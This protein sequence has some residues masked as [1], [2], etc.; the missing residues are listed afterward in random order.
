[1]YPHARLQSA[2]LARLRASGAYAVNIQVAG[3]AG[4]P[5]ILACIA[6]RFVAIEIKV[7]ER[8]L[9]PLQVERARRIEAAGG[10]RWSCGT[11]TI[12]QRSM[13]E[14]IYVSSH[15]LYSCSVDIAVGFPANSRASCLAIA[16]EAYPNNKP[17]MQ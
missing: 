3:D 1:M 16:S 8:R 5:D 11:S 13:L 10:E 12:L 6:G 17:I 14:I 9:R 4:T 7:S 15:Q 2:V